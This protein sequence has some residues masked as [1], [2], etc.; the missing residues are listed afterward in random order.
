MALTLRP[1]FSGVIAIAA[2]LLVSACS[3]EDAGQTLSVKFTTGTSLGVSLTTNGVAGTPAD[4]T[5]SPPI[6]AVPGTP[7]KYT[8]STNIVAKVVYRGKRPLVY[9]WTYSLPGGLGGAG[10]V[11]EASFKIDAT[12]FT[13]IGTPLTL[14][15]DAEGWAILEV[16][17]SDGSLYEKAKV[18]FPV[19][20][21]FSG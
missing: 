6:A 19:Y 16:Y 12:A 9:K 15:P 14:D 18:V 20:V 4:N 10:T 11:S 13:A 8:G 1:I 17:E 2:A 5:V 7:D 21:G 3:S